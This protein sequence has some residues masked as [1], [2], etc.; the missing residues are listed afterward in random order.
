[1]NMEFEIGSG[2]GP[3]PGIYHAEFLR[4][5]ETEHVEFG[6]GLKHVFQVVDGPATGELCS[7]ITSASPTV[8]NSCGR[9]I[10]GITGEA[11]S[12]GQKV[13]LA[14]YVGRRYLLQVES[15]PGGSGTRIATCMPAWQKQ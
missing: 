10:Q 11:L 6:R 7:R 9:M 4:I 3:A 5:E 12:P 15:A 2:G 14:Q 8:K 1:M 13:N